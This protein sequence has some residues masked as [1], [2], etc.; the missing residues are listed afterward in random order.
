MGRGRVVAVLP[1]R[2]KGVVTLELQLLCL[3]V[4]VV[5]RRVCYPRRLT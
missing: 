3:A 5:F 4:D 1:R 2:L